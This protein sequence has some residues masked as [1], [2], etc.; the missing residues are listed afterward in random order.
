MLFNENW[1]RWLRVSTQSYLKT[2]AEGIEYLDA[3]FISGFSRKGGNWE[4]ARLR[5]EIRVTGPFTVKKQPNYWSG[6]MFTNV[7]LALKL[8]EVGDVNDID[9]AAGVFHQALDSGIPMYKL[10]D[11]VCDDGSLIGCLS[12]VAENASPV[13]TIDLGEVD[14]VDQQRQALVTATY[15]I[16]LKN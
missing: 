5:A 8:G 15:F 16:E 7:A 3:I 4:D 12:T 2:V 6:R 14:V 10:G 13:R 9:R 11:S 1:P